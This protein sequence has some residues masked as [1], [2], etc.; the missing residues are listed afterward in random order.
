[1]TTPDITVLVPTYGRPESAL[2][3]ESAVV[4]TST[5]SCKLVFIVEASDPELENYQAAISHDSFA[6]LWVRPSAAGNPGM[7]GALNWAAEKVV[8]PA[9]VGLAHTVPWAIGFM[10]DDHLPKTRGWDREYV[11]AVA[12][13]S[14]V[15]WGDDL[16]QGAVMPTQVAL[17]ANV[18]IALGYMAPR[19]F[20]HLCIDLVW[21]DW[22]DGLGRSC[23]L[24]DV[25]VEH[26][27]PAASKGEWDDNY[28]RVNNS[29]VVASDS[30]LYEKWKVEQLPRELKRLR[31]VYDG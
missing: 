1:M 22:G 12:R 28:N 20:F 17:D 5:A 3:L 15:V 26:L 10:G 23:Y 7:V 16:L 14:A 21:K 19:Q 24:P 27:H 8:F 31:Y 6:E 29:A 25:V 9:S 2:R 4:N 18:V 13:G 11:D 30:A